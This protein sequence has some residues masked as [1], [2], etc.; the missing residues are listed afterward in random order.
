M[1]LRFSTWHPTSKVCV[2]PPYAANVST[3]SNAFSAGT[4]E[5]ACT[6]YMAIHSSMTLTACAVICSGFYFAGRFICGSKG[7]IH[8]ANNPKIL[9]FAL[10]MTVTVSFLTNQFGRKVPGSWLERSEYSAEMYV[11]L[12]PHGNTPTNY[13]LPALIESKKRESTVEDQTFDERVYCIKQA[14]FPGG[15]YISFGNKGE[16]LVFPGKKASVTDDSGKVWN[17]ELTAEE[18]KK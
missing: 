16:Q 9:F 18:V 7:R 6:I 15:G 5:L 10:L 14:R 11:N 12:F 1:D 4:L 2:P 8:E 17:V 3:A 13:R